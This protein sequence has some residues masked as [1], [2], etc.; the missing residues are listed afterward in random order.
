MFD[1]SIHTVHLAPYIHHLTSSIVPVIR[2]QEIVAA[3]SI[4]SHSSGEARLEKLD[5]SFEFLLVEA[6]QNAAALQQ[7]CRKKDKDMRRSCLTQVDAKSN[8]KLLFT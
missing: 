7:M 3:Q 8:P 6:S 1:P 2:P 5:L 4:Y